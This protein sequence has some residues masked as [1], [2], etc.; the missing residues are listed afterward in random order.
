MITGEAGEG[1]MDILFM[2]L[3]NRLQQFKCLKI[4][5][6]LYNKELRCKIIMLGSET[7]T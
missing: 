2:Q 7:L 1:Y 6:T 5:E 4:P 3:F